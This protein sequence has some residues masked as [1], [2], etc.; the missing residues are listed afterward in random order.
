MSP[1][2]TYAIRINSEIREV[3]HASK[4]INY[5]ALNALLASRKAGERALGFAVVARQLRMLTHDLE[6]SMELLDGVIYGL[7]STI[8]SQIRDGRLLENAHA[9]VSACARPPACAVRMEN[10][11][12]QRTLR[13]QAKAE[14][15]WGEFAL[16]YK[17]AC[18]HAEIGQVL[19]RNA[20]VEAAHG[21]SMSGLLGQVAE[22]M[23]QSAGDVCARLRRLRAL[24]ES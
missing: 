7:T 1:D 13:W 19:S 9:A 5:I 10:G 22:Q 18:R 21:G 3:V 2:I 24:I 6:Q 16:H 20:R 4:Q 14:Q 12:R 23:E 8:A 11:L 17:R 15:G